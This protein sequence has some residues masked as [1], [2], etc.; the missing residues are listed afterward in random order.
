[1]FEWLDEELAEIKTPKFH[2]IDGPAP[3][4]LR[5][6]IE[7]CEI[8]LPRSYKE[9]VLRYGT[10][11]LYREGSYYKVTVYAGPRE[12]E[13]KEGDQLVNFGRTDHSLAYFK[14]ALLVEGQESPV[15][16]WA[17]PDGLR[18]TAK[19]FEAW[20]SQ[21]C[22]S[23]R[24]QYDRR[25]WDSILKGPKPF[26]QEEQD[27]VNARKQ[28]RWRVIGVAENGNLLFEVHNG[29]SMTLPYLSIGVRD[30]HGGLE[31]GVW[32][33]VSHVGPLQTAIVEKDCYKAYLD[34]RNAETFAEPDPEPEDR[35][36]YWEFKPIQ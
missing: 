35:D 31:G 10:A 17:E 33:P 12:A 19:G 24:R 22:K 34:P 36:R 28:Y 6:A 5:Q 13:T 14:A 4:D 2:L 15:F 8:A 23:A 27:I 20:I 25:T 16:E 11:K 29:S 7:T 30:K 18:K 26:T 9:F 32:L 3:A 21:K 1:M